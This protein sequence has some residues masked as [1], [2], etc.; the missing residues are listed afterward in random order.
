[1]ASAHRPTNVRSWRYD[2]QSSMTGTGCLADPLLSNVEFEEADVRPTKYVGAGSG[3][4]A[5]N[6]NSQLAAFGATGQ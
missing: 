1:M 2:N 6:R 4:A 5:F 3:L